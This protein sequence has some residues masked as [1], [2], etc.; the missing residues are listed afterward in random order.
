MVVPEALEQPLTV[1][2]FQ[3]QRDETIYTRTVVEMAAVQESHQMR[4]V[5]GVIL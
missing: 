3:F 4:A 2:E 5:Q 1:V